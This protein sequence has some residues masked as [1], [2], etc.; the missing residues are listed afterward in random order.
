MRRGPSLLPD[1]CRNVRVPRPSVQCPYILHP[2]GDDF[3]EP[4]KRTLAARVGNLCS[5]PACGTLT[6]GPQADPAKAINL[7]VAA[8]IT[9][10]SPGGPR[11][12]P[13]LLAEE[14]SAPGN[15]IWLCQNCAKL[16]DNDIAR[17]SIHVLRTWKL[18][19]ESEAQFRLGKTSISPRSTPV[20]LEQGAKLRIAPIVP[21][22]HEQSEFCVENEKADYLTFKKLDSSRQVDIPKS[23]V[24]Q[25]HKLGDAKPALLQ[26][27]GRLQWISAKRNFELFHEKP[28]AGPAGAYGIG[29]DVDPGYVAQL[30]IPGTCSFVREDRLPRLLLQRWWVYYDVDGAYLRWPGPDINQIL[31][32]NWV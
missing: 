1:R 14:R 23:F 6:S 31:I 12:D 22:Q 3:S 16:V 17:F 10:A 7:G 15:G 18:D 29:K 20:R 26:L 5:N 19:A 28:P 9:A 4:V 27:A 32:V 24:E 21:R 13:G 30:A 11:Y 8:H 2:M 25:I